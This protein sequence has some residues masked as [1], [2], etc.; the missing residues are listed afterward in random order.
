[1][2]VGAVALVATGVGAVIGGTAFLAATGVSLAT[3]SAIGTVAGVI[4]SM[5]AKRPSSTVGGSQTDFKLDPTASVPMHFGRTFNG[6]YIVDR[7]TWGDENQ[8]QG[9]IVVYSG[10]GP[11][12]SI[13]E[14]QVDRAPVTFGLDGMAVGTYSGF[15]WHARQLGH[16]PE[17]VAVPIPV[18]GFPGRDA[19]SKLS[20]MAAGSFTLKFDKKGKK[21]QG[22]VPRNGIVGEGIMSYDPRL[23]STY[24]GGDGPCR[25]NDQATWVYS[26][27]PWINGLTFAIGF[28]QN[29]KPVGGVQSDISK[30]IVRQWVEAA[31]VADA[32]GW[33]SGGVVYT[34][35]NK[36]NVLKL[37]AE[38]GC[39]EPQW[40]GALLGCQVSK[41]RVSVATIRTKDVRGPVRIVGTQTRRGGRI[42]GVIPVY[43]SEAHGWEPIPADVVRVSTYVAEDGELRTRES[44]Y[45][46]VQDLKQAAVLAAYEIVNGREFGPISIPLGIEWIGLEPG[47]ALDLDIP[48]VDLVDLQ[49]VVI[50]KTFEPG[51]GLIKVDLRSETPEKHPFALGATTTAPPTPSL[52]PPDYDELEAYFE[53]DVVKIDRISNSRII[54]D[55]GAVVTISD[56]AVNIGAH[57]RIYADRTVLVSAGS[58]TGLIPSTVYYLFYDKSSRTGGAVVWQAT[59]VYAEAF[60]DDDSPGRHYGGYVQTGAAG[61]AGSGVGPIPPS[62]GDPAWQV[63]P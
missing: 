50:A 27:N 63:D 36:W 15:M 47:M 51:T 23:D 25:W 32:N 19:S 62:G 59:T 13:Q 29:G 24:P 26:E 3:V 48:E 20:G 10:C 43:R 40:S 44:K 42:N 11:M 28:K 9:F 4:G 30:I 35:D 31:N 1:M 6:G 37:F 52:D 7:D 5:T 41:P 49:A 56:T 18:P 22:G 17:P 54:M 12:K 61:L 57:S 16:C 60:P 8:Y 45:M 46:L 39:G 38:A 33:K 14:F 58:V 55:P 2:I 21:F 34:A 53:T